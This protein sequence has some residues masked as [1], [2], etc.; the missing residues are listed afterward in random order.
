MKDYDF[1]INGKKRL[2][3]ILISH[4]KMKSSDPDHILKKLLYII[5]HSRYLETAQKKINKL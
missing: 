3:S 5:E 1:R 4:Y 2:D